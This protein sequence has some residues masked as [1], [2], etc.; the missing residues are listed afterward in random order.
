MRE[1]EFC[2]MIREYDWEPLSKVHA[3]AHSATIGYWVDWWIKQYPK[4]GRVIEP[5]RKVKIEKIG[6]LA[7]IEFVGFDGKKWRSVGVGEIENNHS[8][9]CDKLKTLHLYEKCGKFRNLKFAL[10][11]TYAVIDEKGN[12]SVKKAIRRKVLKNIKRAV[13]YAREL[14]RKSGLYWVIYILKIVSEE[15]QIDEDEPYPGTCGGGEWLIFRKG[16]IVEHE[17][18]GK[19]RK[20]PVD[21]Y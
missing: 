18:K 17:T 1:R 12:V 8:K 21:L 4:E 15:T 6:R 5:A 11:C 2:G 20:I 13:K 7:D 10:L 3:E 16:R 19:G 9:L 14:S